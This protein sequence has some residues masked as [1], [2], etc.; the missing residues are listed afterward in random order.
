MRFSTKSWIALSAFFLAF[1]FVVPSHAQLSS[2]NAT[3]KLNAILNES[4][5]VAAGPATVNFTPLAPNGPT[6]GDNP[7]SITTTWA[8]VKTRGSVKLYAY[9]AGANALTDGAGDNIPV[10]NVSGSVNGVAAVPF[11]T[12]APFG[13][14]GVLVFSQ[15]LSIGL[16]LDRR[17]NAYPMGFL[18]GTT[19]DRSKLFGSHGQRPW[20]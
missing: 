14:T 1:V 7:V 17:P 2:N 3:V 20:V 15:T 8:L 16:S 5:T 10:A 4:L 12:A 18:G 19:P 9:F 13:G 6:A 11:T